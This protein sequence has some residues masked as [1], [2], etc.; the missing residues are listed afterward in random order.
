MKLV[1]MYIQSFLASTPNKIDKKINFRASYL[2]RLKAFSLLGENFIFSPPLESQKFYESA[3]C[4]SG[5]FELCFY[6]KYSG[7]YDV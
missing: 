3:S 5:K 7:S 2:K 4:L 6:F 1:E